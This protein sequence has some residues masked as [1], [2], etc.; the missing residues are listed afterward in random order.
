MPVAIALLIKAWSSLHRLFDIYV[1]RIGL[2]FYKRLVDVFRSGD[3][4]EA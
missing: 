4:G 2:L 1:R 3:V